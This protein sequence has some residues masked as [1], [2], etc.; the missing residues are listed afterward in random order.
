MVRGLQIRRFFLILNV[1]LGGLLLSVA[2]RNLWMTGPVPGPLGGLPGDTDVAAAA[3]AYAPVVEGLSAYESLRQS[4][5][6]GEAGRWNPNA[7]P[8][9][10]A[11]P[12]KASEEP[13]L[14]NTQL[15]LLGTMALSPG[16]PA[17]AAFIENTAEQPGAKGYVV[18]DTVAEGVTLLEIFP[19]RVILENKSDGVAKKEYLSME[20]PGEGESL[21]AAAGAA[22]RG[23]PGGVPPAVRGPGSHIRTAKN[24]GPAKPDAS[25]KIQLN[26]TEFAKDLEDNYETLLKVR[27][28][29]KRDAKG[30]FVGLTADNISQ[31]PMAAKLGFQDGDVLQTINGQRIQNEQQVMEIIQQNPD[32]RSFQIG[33][34]RGGQPQ[35]FTYNLNQ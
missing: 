22:G 34:L 1:V 18:G 9:A 3:I 2:A 23:K 35:T 31:Y 8:P 14:A 21:M 12:P 5:L 17:S 28:V 33:I 10:P 11:E 27:P 20:E 32:A 30:N 15:R 25:G 7:A 6:F 16:Q 19:R 4:G 24:T 26:L 29:E 13:I